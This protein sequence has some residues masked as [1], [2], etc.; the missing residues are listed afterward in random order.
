MLSRCDVRTGSRSSV[1]IQ[2][3]LHTLCQNAEYAQGL[4]IY[5]I[6]PVLL[7]VEKELLEHIIQLGEGYPAK[8]ERKGIASCNDSSQ[9]T[10]SNKCPGEG[11]QKL[12][13]SGKAKTG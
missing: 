5:A 12:I 13:G 9:E 6:G 7:G 2:I 8:V 10:G 4:D 3:K 11:T 1:C